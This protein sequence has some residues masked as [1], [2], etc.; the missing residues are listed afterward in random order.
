MLGPGQLCGRLGV[1]QLL[2][3]LGKLAE[4]ACGGHPPGELVG[5]I[6]SFLDLAE[7]AHELLRRHGLEEGLARLAR[8][9]DRLESR[10]EL[11]LLEATLLDLL[12]QRQGEQSQHVEQDGTLDFDDSTAAQT[13]EAERGVGQTPRADPVRLGD[14]ELGI[15]RLQAAVVE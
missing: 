11:R 4:V 10:L 5:S 12:G 13:A 3:H 8:D 15:A 1:E 14:A 9:P 6:R 7:V 2:A